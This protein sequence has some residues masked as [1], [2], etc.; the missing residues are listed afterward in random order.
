MRKKTPFQP[1]LPVG[2]SLTALPLLPK[3]GSI[4]VDERQQ[5]DLQR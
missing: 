4:P 2:D 1:P 3:G 5:A